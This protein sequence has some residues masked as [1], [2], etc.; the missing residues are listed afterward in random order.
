MPSTMG[1]DDMKALDSANG[2]PFNRKLLT[3]TMFHHRGAIEVA[4]A[5][6]ADGNPDAVALATKI[7]AGQTAELA[8]MKGML[9][10]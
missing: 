5:G 8:Q 7:E 3:M 1:D 4:K 9:K 10:S 2:A 6:Q